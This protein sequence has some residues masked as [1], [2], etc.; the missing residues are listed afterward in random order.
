MVLISSTSFSVPAS[1]VTANVP[2]GTETL[3]I[4]AGQMEDRI[5]DFRRAGSAIH[6]FDAETEILTLV[7]YPSFFARVARRTAIIPCTWLARS[8]RRRS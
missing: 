6:A 8:F 7:L 4:D 3:V 2:A 5:L 1:Y